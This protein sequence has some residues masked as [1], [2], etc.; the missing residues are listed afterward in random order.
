MLAEDGSPFTAHTTA[1]VPFAARGLRGHGA[2][3][4]RPPGSALR[5]RAH[6]ARARG[7]RPEA[8]GHDG[9]ESAGLSFRNRRTHEKRRGPRLRRFVRFGGAYTNTVRMSSM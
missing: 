7:P 5:H 8:R 6:A 2:H 3:A 9:E 1:L 4:R